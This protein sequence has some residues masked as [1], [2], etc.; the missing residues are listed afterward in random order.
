MNNDNDWFD[1][2]TYYVNGE[3]FYVRKEHYDV[4]TMIVR[5]EAETYKKQAEEFR[6]AAND[7]AVELEQTNKELEEAVYWARRLA[8]ERE[9]HL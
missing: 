3:K 2:Y 5:G 6:K 4:I 8:R 7:L 9:H 1:G